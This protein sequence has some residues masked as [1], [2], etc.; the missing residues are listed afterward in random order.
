MRFPLFNLMKNKPFYLFIIFF[1]L[2]L[3]YFYRIAD[4]P[5]IRVDESWVTQASH[6]LAN[7]GYFGSPM[8]KGYYNLEGVTHINPPLYY[9]CLGG[10]FKIFGTGVI[11]GRIL[12]MFFS[13]LSVFVFFKI[14]KYQFPD[15]DYSI[16]ILS[17]ILILSSPIF[18]IFAKTIR[19]EA[20]IFLFSLLTYY[21]I[22]RAIREKDKVFIFLAGMTSALSMLSNVSGAFIFIY[23]FILI[24][25]ENYKYII[26]YLTGFSIPSFVYFLWIMQ[27]F[28]AFYGQVII[29]RSS[30]AVSLTSK[31]YG[32]IDFLMSKAKVTL[33]LLYLI[34]IMVFSKIINVNKIDKHYLKYYFL[35][36]VSFLILMFLTTHAG[37]LYFSI[38]IPFVALNFIYLYSKTTNKLCILSVTVLLIIVN[39]FGLFTYHNLYSS[40][41]YNKY[42]NRLVANIPAG[43]T[44]LGP[45][46]CYIGLANKPYTYR[47]F[48]NP[49]ITKSKTLEK[50]I[51]VIQDIGTEYIVVDSTNRTYSGILEEYYNRYAVKFDSFIS[52]D[53]GS[54]GNRRNNQIV[55]YKV[56]K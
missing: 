51:P 23:V 52:N 33:Y 45:T 35:P 22:V 56:L 13:F 18:Y 53:Y 10:V 6:S 34:I 44:V 24:C 28:S 1:I 15:I 27:D 49:N 20:L 37:P 40:F 11:Q 43:A 38:L 3:F 36:I 9:L 42:I 25:I 7:E 41:N 17:G 5:F 8:F 47:A 48:D 21:L 19:P 2:V 26:F 46:S 39:F 31:F 54:E 55:I 14:I 50:L 32:M 4:F 29:F 12:S 30:E 16:R